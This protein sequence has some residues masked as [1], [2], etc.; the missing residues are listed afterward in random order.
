MSPTGLLSVSRWYYN[1]RPAEALR[2]ASIAAEA[3]RRRGVENP[4]DH[5]ALIKI[6]KAPGVAGKLGNGV[7]TMLV[8][9]SPLGEAAIDA[10]EQ[11]ADRMG[12]VPVLKPLLAEHPVF[13][14]II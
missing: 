5:V 9:P 3:L 4:R 11:V 6:E 10:L 12:F 1:E 2:L 14:S 7:G 13:V 8:S